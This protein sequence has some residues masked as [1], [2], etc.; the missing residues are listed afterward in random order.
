MKGVLN[1]CVYKGVLKH[2]HDI[3]SLVINAV[4]CVGPLRPVVLTWYTDRKDYI[5]QDIQTRALKC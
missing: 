2:T 5:C 3:L 4:I 1:L